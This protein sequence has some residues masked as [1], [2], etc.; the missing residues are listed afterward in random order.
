MDK[1][2]LQKLRHAHY[3]VYNHSAVEI[4]H[5]TKEAIREG[6]GCYK[7]RFYGIQTHRCMEFTPTALFCE[8]RCVHCWRMTDFY[9]MLRMP[10]GAVDEPEEI[11][12]RLMAERRKL[13]IGFLG[14]PEVDREWLEEALVPSHFAISLSG[15][16]T[17]YPKLPQ[18]IRYL[19]ALPTTQSVFL[20]TNGQEPDMLERLMRE[21]A[22]PTQLYLSMNAFNRDDYYR[23]NKPMYRDAWER[24]LRSL[25]M[26]RVMNTRT[27]IR[28]TLMKGIND[29]AEEIPEAAELIRRGMPHFVEIKSYMHIGGSMSNLGKENMLEMSE[30]R[31]YSMKVLKHLPEFSYMDEHER[32]RISVLQNQGRKA[33]R[34][35]VPGGAYRTGAP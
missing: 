3:G 8:N 7:N 35:I 15:E 21:D 10:E 34:W 12:K 13:L 29:S 17:M 19:R 30:I 22:L 28:I 25:D 9:R 4:C 2:S 18:L 24:W 16:P 31:D 27:V 1:E 11:V 26:L 23:V 6:E 32:S 20:V 5:W 33:D 14:N